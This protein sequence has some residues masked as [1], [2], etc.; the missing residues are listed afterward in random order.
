ML[1]GITLLRAPQGNM[2]QFVSV[3]ESAHPRDPIDAV[4]ALHLALPA[5]KRPGKGKRPVQKGP[6]V[7]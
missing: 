2:Q 7:S 6:R 5:A 3:T 4:R 1:C